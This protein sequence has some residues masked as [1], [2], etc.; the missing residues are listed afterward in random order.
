MAEPILR[1]GCWFLEVEV[2]LVDVLE[3][4]PWLLSKTCADILK[5]D[6]GEL[7]WYVYLLSQYVEPV[8]CTSTFARVWAGSRELG[9]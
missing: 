9:P 2:M 7:V 6:H 4:K 3:G 8:K 5:K 1:D